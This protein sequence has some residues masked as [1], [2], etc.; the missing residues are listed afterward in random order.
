[1]PCSDSTFS[2]NLH[3]Q[4]TPKIVYTWKLKWVDIQCKTHKKW[5]IVYLTSFLKFL[6]LLQITFE[7]K[8]QIFFLTISIILQI[9]IIKLLSLCCPSINQSPEK[10]GFQSKCKISQKSKDVKLL[11]STPSLSFILKYIAM[12]ISYNIITRVH[13]ILHNVQRQKSGW[14]G[15]GGQ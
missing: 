6:I 13:R 4:L 11:L 10:V 14:R 12:F 15:I 8:L 7:I 5:N 3:I 2:A 1:M 9:I